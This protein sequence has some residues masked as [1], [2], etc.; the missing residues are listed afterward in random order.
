MKKLFFSG[1]ISCGLLL[2]AAQT[3]GQTL[4][5]YTENNNIILRW[6]AANEKFIDRYIVE[7]S[8]DGVY[9]TPLHEVV[10]QG[11]FTDEGDHLYQDADT[12]PPGPTNFYRVRTVLSEGGSLY[13]PIVKVDVNTSDR[14]VLKPTVIHQGGTIRLDNF[15]SNQLLSINIF[16]ARGTLLASYLVNSTDFNINT[17]HL[18][19]GIVFYRISDEKHALIDAGKLMIL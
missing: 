7:R 13:S 9:F 2:A 8:S 18:A 11:P 3:S 19:K 14:P 17:D 16:N 6:T 1:L 5:A 10:S 12:Y 15:H 4:F